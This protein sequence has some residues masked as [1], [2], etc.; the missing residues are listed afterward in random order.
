MSFFLQM[1]VV[2]LDTIEQILLPKAL[3]ILLQ[4]AY[5]THEQ[6]QLAVAGSHV[7]PAYW[8]GTRSASEIAF[9]N[10]NQPLSVTAT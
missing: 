2:R 3:N 1:E 8:P 10:S 9:L 6:A 7:K 4:A 5:Q